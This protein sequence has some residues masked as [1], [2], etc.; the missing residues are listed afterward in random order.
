MRKAF[1]C[2][3][4]FKKKQ[5]VLSKLLPVQRLRQFVAVNRTRY[6]QK[7]NCS[8]LRIE[9]IAA[10][11]FRDL[12]AETKLMISN[13]FRRTRRSKPSSIW[14]MQQE[15]TIRHW[16]DFR[17]ATFSKRCQWSIS[18]PLE[19]EQSCCNYTF[20]QHNCLQSRTLNKQKYIYL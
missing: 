17:S 12:A 1:Y 19:V 13:S 9:Y 8:Y 15:V 5:P 3:T 6:R 16:S 4:Y 10:P 14:A 2:L 7:R 11:Y 20:P 18:I